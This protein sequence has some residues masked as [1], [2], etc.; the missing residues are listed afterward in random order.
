A[1]TV[2]RVLSD[3]LAIISQLLADPE[4]K[5]SSLPSPERRGRGLLVDTSPKIAAAFAPPSTDAER[6]LVEIWQRLLNRQTI[7]IHD[8]FFAIGGQSML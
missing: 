6:T 5:L 8:D 2:E 7:G 4:V 3:Y 1:A